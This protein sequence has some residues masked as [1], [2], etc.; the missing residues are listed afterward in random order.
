M[1][2]VFAISMTAEDDQPPAVHMLHVHSTTAQQLETCIILVTLYEA[3]LAVC[4][5]AGVSTYIC[6]HQLMRT[7][8][9]LNV[10]M[11]CTRFWIQS[12]CPIVTKQ[13]VSCIFHD[14][15]HVLLTSRWCLCWPQ[16]GCTAR[17]ELRDR[18]CGS[19]GQVQGAGAGHGHASSRQPLR[20]RGVCPGGA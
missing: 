20:H 11:C 17:G 3:S 15:L 18:L 10:C 14:A 1:S 5:G 19:G 2:P 6:V 7:I 4:S 8:G 9:G 12:M 13:Q 16:V